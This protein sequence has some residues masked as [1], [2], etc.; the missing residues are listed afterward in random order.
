MRNVIVFAGAG[1][2]KAVDPQAYP[3]TVEFFERLP[4]EV[5]NDTLFALLTKHLRRAVAGSPAI[6]IEQVLWA[7]QELQTFLDAVTNPHSV[8]GWFLQDSRL[9]QPI[10]LTSNFNNLT[11]NAPRVLEVVHR[12]RHAIDTQVYDL[13]GRV[14]SEEQIL[15]NW[16][17]L[18]DTLVTSNVR[19]DIFTTN[20]DRIIEVALRH[21]RGSS[22]VR[23]DT[24]R[25]DEDVERYLDD[26]VWTES[27]TRSTGEV[28]LLTKLH[29]S[30]DWSWDLARER[31]FISDPLFKGDHRRHVILYPGFKG[32]P[33]RPPFN[34]FHSYFASRLALVDH[35]IFIGFA[36]RDEYIN[37]MLQRF[38]APRAIVTVVNPVEVKSP[39]AAEVQHIAAPFAADAVKQVLQRIEM[40]A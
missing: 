11:E 7:L 5:K 18:L 6:D 2:S 29:G 16:L 22:V 17:R 12:L 4:P 36:F 21:V 25:R 1:A 9:L 10:S 28:G 8:P 35:I 34:Y 40:A 24:G 20:Y 33:D 23:V 39:F 38:T 13:Y 30:V 31:I 15:T 27:S 37:D 19:V 3:T 26:R 32:V 14:P